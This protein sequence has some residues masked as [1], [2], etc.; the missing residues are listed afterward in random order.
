[1]TVLNDLGRYYVASDDVNRL[2]KLGNSGAHFKRMV[3]DLLIE[4]KL[5]IREH[6]DKMPEVRN[7][8]ESY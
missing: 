7:S 2:R 6:G 3:R 1:M 8:T 5:Y 4:H